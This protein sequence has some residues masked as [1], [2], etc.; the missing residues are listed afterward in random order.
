MR[1]TACILRIAQSSKSFYHALI[2]FVFYTE[3]S[4]L[5]VSYCHFAHT[6]V[7][8]TVSKFMS[9]KLALCKRNFSQ[10]R[11]LL[12][13]KKCCTDLCTTTCGGETCKLIVIAIAC[14]VHHHCNSQCFTM[15]TMRLL[16][17]VKE[18]IALQMW[19]VKVL[20]DGKTAVE[21]LS[22]LTRHTRSVNVVR[23]SPDGGYPTWNL[24]Y[25]VV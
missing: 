3:R 19:E 20:P 7:T 12:L 14:D 4:L 22:T 6:H 2:I 9:G 16:A 10:L 13:H 15:D 17:I 25:S 5:C 1:P 21:F 11:T 18:G 8:G 24:I 23:F